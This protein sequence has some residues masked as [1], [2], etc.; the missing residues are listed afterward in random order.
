MWIIKKFARDLFSKPFGLTVRV[1][2]RGIIS[3]SLLYPKVIIET[4]MFSKLSSGLKYLFS[5]T[6]VLKVDSL[7]LRIKPLCQ[8]NDGRGSNYEYDSYYRQT[9]LA[10]TVTL[11]CASNVNLLEDTKNFQGG[12][13]SRIFT[14]LY[15]FKI[16]NSKSSII[17]SEM[18]VQSLFYTSRRKVIPIHAYIF[19]SIAR[20]YLQFQLILTRKITDHKMYTIP[21]ARN[22]HTD[23]TGQDLYFTN[24]R[25]CT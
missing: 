13:Q 14:D 17:E 21:F 20:W 25:L 24:Q 23:V 9:S 7:I 8:K 6:A 12:S 22:A 10:Q 2:L 1:S 19:V 11:Y 4:L 5:V 16:D 18:L 3:V 15:F